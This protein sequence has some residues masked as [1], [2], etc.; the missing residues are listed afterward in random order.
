MIYNIHYADDYRGGLCEFYAHNLNILY[1]F[2]ITL[3]RK[4][5]QM[6]VNPTLAKNHFVKYHT[7]N[8]FLIRSKC[9]TITQLSN[10]DNDQLL[11]KYNDSF[12]KTFRSAYNKSPFYKKLYQEN[13]ITIDEIKDITDIEKLPLINRQMI[14]DNIND[15]YIGNNLFKVK[16]LTSG[17]SGS[18]LTVFRTPLSIIT[19]LS[20]ISNFRKLHGFNFGQPM[21]SIRGYLN[22][23]KSHEYF[24][25]ANILY[26]SG[27]NI[28]ENTIEEYYKLIKSFNPVAIEAFPSY[29]Y[30]LFIELEKKG[31]KIDIPISFTSSEIL[32]DFQRERIEPFFNTS[33]FDWYGN[34]ERSIGIAQ[35]KDLKYSPL[36][37]YSIN[38]YKKNSVIT[39]SLINQSFPLIRYEIDDRISLASDDFLRN[40]SSPEILKIEGRA[41]DTIE[42]KDGSIVGCIDHAFKGVKNLE[43]A[44]IHQ[45]DKRE[46]IE[47]KILVNNKFSV[48]DEKILKSNLIKML[49]LDM[50]FTFNYCNQEDFTFNNSN[51]YKLI[52]KDNK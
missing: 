30:K 14:K 38:E 35:G 34:V 52:I 47:I 20:Y 46:P 43:Y 11:N 36:P 45:Y 44:Q 19:E 26:I 27:S 12:L 5:K 16:G 42:L 13:G 17:T 9:K 33:I 15:I 48:D 6:E 51:K 24:K 25:K 31:L 49:G 29:L 22:K 39:T 18:P 3:N 41:G 28:N 32:Y 2:G 40:I 21:L 23:L 7:N 1:N 50:L 8:N 37:L 4:I 10:L